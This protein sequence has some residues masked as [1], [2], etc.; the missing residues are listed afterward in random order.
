VA[1]N[2]GMADIEYIIQ[3]APDFMTPDAYLMFEHGYDQAAAVRECLIE[4]GFA[5]VESF[6]DLGGNDRVTIGQYKEK[7]K[8]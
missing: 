6:Q 3:T 5:V 2:H 8:R 7:S 4:A 1:D